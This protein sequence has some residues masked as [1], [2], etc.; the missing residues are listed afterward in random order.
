MSKKKKCREICYLH[1]KVRF[2]HLIGDNMQKRDFKMQKTDFSTLILFDTFFVTSFFYT[3]L[4]HFFF[5]SLI[6][7]TSF[8][9]FFEPP[10]DVNTTSLHFF[11]APQW[12]SIIIYR[13]FPGVRKEGNRVSGG[14]TMG[15]S[16]LRGS[17][18]A[19]PGVEKGEIASP[20]VRKERLRASKCEYKSVSG[21]CV[22][23]K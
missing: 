10:E 22:C 20:A 14:R 18:R 4:C 17:D 1:L 5:S 2:L 19:S 9:H 8:R 16:R 23:R 12:C 15:K 3:Y 21:K 11:W 6:F 7:V 13:E